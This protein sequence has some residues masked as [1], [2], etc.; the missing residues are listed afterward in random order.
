MTGTGFE[1]GT[2][3]PITIV[4]GVDGSASSL[5]AAAYAGGLARRQGATLIGVYVRHPVGGVL[6]VADRTGTGIALEQRH[7]AQVETEL[8]NSFEHIAPTYG[9]D[10]QFV[11]SNG[12]PFTEICRLAESQRADAVVVGASM[13][14]GHRV[15]GSLAI[16][17]VRQ[18][19]WPVTVVP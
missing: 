18:A 3:G 1:L 4:V 17:L 9:I 15:A 16:R 19:K 10:A 5:R 2:D 11:V 13:S 14:M 7:Q 6:A 8:R 12:D